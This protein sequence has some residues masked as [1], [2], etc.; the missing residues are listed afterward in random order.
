MVRVHESRE[1]LTNRTRDNHLKTDPRTDRCENNF[2]AGQRQIRD[3]TFRERRE[4]LLGEEGGGGR[5][6]ES[7]RSF[8]TGCA[9]NVDDKKRKRS[10]NTE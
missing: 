2:I 6:R 10:R 3:I 5:E 4:E 7:V 8:N 1:L 9:K